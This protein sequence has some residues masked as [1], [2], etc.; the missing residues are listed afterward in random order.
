MN[1]PFLAIDAEGHYG[2]EA[3]VYGVHQTDKT[4]KRAKGAGFQIIDTHGNASCKPGDKIK[5]GP[6]QDLINSGQWSR[7]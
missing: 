3:R 2:N 1:G 6:L 5:R 7:V 4:A